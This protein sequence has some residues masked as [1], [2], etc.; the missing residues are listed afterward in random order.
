VKSFVTGFA[1]GTLILI[2]GV[3]AYLEM[4]LAEIRSDDP[5]SGWTRHFLYSATHAAV[6]RRAP[7]QQNPLPADEQVLI[8]G[9]KLY[10]NDCVGCHGEPGKP[11]SE[12]GASF[13]PPAPQLDRTA[14]KYTE[15]E[16]FWIAKHGIRRTGMSAQGNSYSD[17]DLWRLAA[18]IRRM[19]QLPPRVME[20]IQQPFSQPSTDHQASR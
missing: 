20:G 10:L 12:F 19:T 14:T 16:I 3:F 17:E 1:C 8:A 15:A 11:T 5:P 4:G 2:L 6:R 7:I 18:F 9:G 13:Y